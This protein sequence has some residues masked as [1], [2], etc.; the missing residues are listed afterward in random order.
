M[1]PS[2]RIIDYYNKAGYPASLVFTGEPS[3]KKKQFILDTITGILEREQITEHQLTFHE[4]AE[5][6]YGNEHPDYYYFPPAPIKIGDPVNP[7]PGTIRHL[8]GKFLPY[9][10]YKSKTRIV[11]FDDAG[12]IKNEA[13]SALLKSME[14]PPSYVRFFLSVSSTDELKDTI[15]SRSVAVPMRKNQ[16][17]ELL[18][19][20]LWERFWAMSGYASDPLFLNARKK[21][22]PRIIREEYDKMVFSRYDYSL[23]ENL[24]W[25]KVRSVFRGAGTTE[26]LFYAKMAFLPVFYA[27]RDRIIYGGMIPSASPIALPFT[28]RDHLFCLYTAIQDLYRNIEVRVFGNMPL[29]HRAVI[30]SFLVKFLPCWRQA[31]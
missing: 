25:N 30:F 5:K 15:L 18:P 14:E 26:Q 1:E 24:G 7:E 23:F 13:E 29:S 3:R 17:G 12:G 22:W 27:I 4:I 10:G 16:E 31:D 20:D 8:L 6:I 28:D 11:Y 19:E 21:E 9:S 2:A